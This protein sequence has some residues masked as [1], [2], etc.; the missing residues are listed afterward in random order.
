MVDWLQH[1]SSFLQSERLT[2]L[3]TG[4]VADDTI[5]CQDCQ[6]IGDK[7]IR[8]IVGQNFHDVKLSEKNK[9]VPLS[10]LNWSLKTHE[11]VIPVDTNLLYQRIIKT[12]HDETELM[13]CFQYELSP[14]P[15]TLF[16][17]RGMRKGVKSAL[18]SFFDPC[19]DLDQSTKNWKFVI[20]WGYVL[21]CYIALMLKLAS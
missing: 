21:V 9:V 14:F 3:S 16:D 15:Q 4:L 12:M 18:D 19:L 1:D 10:A 13:K 20:D 17:E 5:N 6:E 11:I 2:S 8:G 7:S